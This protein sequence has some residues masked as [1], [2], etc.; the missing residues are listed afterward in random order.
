[1]AL[2][3]VTSKGL[4]CSPA[5]LYIDPWRAV[6]R[7][8]ITHAHSDHARGGSGLY[9][10]HEHCVPLL[11]ARLGKIQA[12]G[13]SYGSTLY[14]NGVRISFHPAGHVPGSAQIRLEYKGEV[15]VVSG[16]YKT[17]ADGLTPAFEPVPCHTFI[18]EST[19]GL[20]VYNWRPQAEV[21]SDINEWW[22]SNSAEDVVSVVVAYSLGKAQRILKHL[23]P[24]IGPVLVHP[25]VAEMNAV[26]RGFLPLPDCGILHSKLSV[27]DYRNALLLIPP[28]ATGTAGTERFRP[29]ATASASGWMS[30]RGARRW[31]AYDRG[32]VLSDHADWK[33]LV[34]AVKSSGAERIFVTHGYTATFV[35]WLREQGYDAHELNTLFEGDRSESQTVPA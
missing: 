25:A 18:T 29:S 28:A 26:I 23:D 12:Q 1:M 35:R 20:P 27:K 6:P 15:W 13:Y 22:A 5:D 7:A 30:L 14:V 10:A 24:H 9:L 32:F 2:V 4:Y 21:F 19:F 8:L 11:K 33:G 31:N 16:D 17:E 3:E 34:G